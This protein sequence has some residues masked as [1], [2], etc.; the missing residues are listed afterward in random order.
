ITIT[1]LYNSML[2]FFFSSRRR[3]TRWPRDWSSDVCSSD[4]GFNQLLLAPVVKAAVV[5]QRH[6]RRDGEFG[7]FGNEEIAG[8]FQIR[9]SPEVQPLAHVVAFIHA[10]EDPRPRVCHFRPVGHE[11]EDFSS[12][13]SLPSVEILWLVMEKSKGLVRLFLLVLNKW[14]QI[15]KRRARPG[16]GCVSRGSGLR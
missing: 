12:C 5:M 15:S 8:H 4:L 16:V 6:D 13:F 1:K 14:V 10:L 2:I 3:H 11:L 9:S 7:A